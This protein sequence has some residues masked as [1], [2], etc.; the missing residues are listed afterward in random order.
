MKLLQL[1]LYIAIFTFS[2]FVFALPGLSARQCDGDVCLWDWVDDAL[3]GLVGGAGWVFNSLTGLLE[4]SPS[5]QT[6]STLNKN[7]APPSADPEAELWVV[8][9]ADTEDKCSTVSDSSPDTD[10]SRVSFKFQ[11]STSGS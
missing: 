8:G 5:P 10:S 2:S 7:E 6:S 1:N 9:P 3:W 4:P 11:C